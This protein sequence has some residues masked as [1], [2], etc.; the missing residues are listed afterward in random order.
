MVDLQILSGMRAGSNFRGAKFPIRVGRAEGLDLS[1]DESGVW[2]KHFQIIW[3]SQGLMLEAE[4]DALVS[5]NDVAVRQ[6]ALRNGDIITLGSLKL[7]FNLS[8]VRQSSI[9]LREWLTW[10]GLG[11]LCL[12]QVTLVY[13]LLRL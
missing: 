13:L 5:V 9:A 2:P 12:G 11:A 4:P 3:Q 8:A 10:I 1:V 7:R 6:A